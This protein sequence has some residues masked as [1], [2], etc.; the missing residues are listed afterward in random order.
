MK[1]IRKN[2]L[3][4]TEKEAAIELADEARNYINMFEH[5]IE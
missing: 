1:R 5:L 4:L 3:L 2:W